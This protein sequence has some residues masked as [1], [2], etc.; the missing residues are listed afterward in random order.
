MK[1]LTKIHIE[2]HPG[3]SIRISPECIEKPMKIGK[4]RWAQFDREY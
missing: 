4:I 1:S 3:D 2:I